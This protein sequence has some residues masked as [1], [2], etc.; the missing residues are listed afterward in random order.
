MSL[1]TVYF[2]LTAWVDDIGIRVRPQSGR[3]GGAHRSLREEHLGLRTLLREIDGDLQATLD[4]LGA[5]ALDAGAARRARQGLAMLA[6]R[7]PGH[8]AREE[9]GGY[10]SAALGEA[11]RYHESARVLQ[12]QHAAFL[13]ESSRLRQLVRRAG[14]SVASWEELHVAWGHLA[15]ALVAHE[16]AE[17]EIIGAALLEDLGAGD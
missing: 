16:K 17:S 4:G 6:R 14:G 13:E 8:F 2:R 1:Q 10:L 5:G 7:L 11:P 15:G 3:R 9:D 12:E